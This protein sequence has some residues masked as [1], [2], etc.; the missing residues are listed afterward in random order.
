MTDYSC[1]NCGSEGTLN[2][3]EAP[4]APD[5]WVERY[6]CVDCSNTYEIAFHM[7]G[8]DPH[9]RLAKHVLAMEDDSYLTGHPEW[10]EIV[11]DAKAALGI[12]SV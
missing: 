11:S 6:T 5:E 9:E 12:A 8:L 10:L 3:W 7:E 4:G 2:G 1:P